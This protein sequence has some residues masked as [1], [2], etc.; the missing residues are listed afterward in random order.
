[1]TGVS[2]FALT[3]GIEAI[4]PIEIG[5]PTVRAEI[6]EKENVKAIVKDLDTI[7]ELWEAAVVHIAS[8]QKRL[9]NLHNRRVKL[10]TFLLGELVLRRVFENTTNL[11][12]GKFQPNWEGHPGTA[13]SYV[14]S[15]P[16]GTAVPK[17]WNVMHLKKYY[18]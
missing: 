12:D 2:P 9:E 4:I 5:I 6:P 15:R 18:Q 11:V 10:C 17:M 3:Y 16:D 14:L 1:M 8:Y 7:D 13:G